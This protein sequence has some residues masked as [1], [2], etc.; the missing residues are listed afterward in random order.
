MYPA[1]FR[2]SYSRGFLTVWLMLC[3]I[4]LPC[5]RFLLKPS[6]LMN[7]KRKTAIAVTM[8]NMTNII[9]HTEALK[10]SEGGE[11]IVKMHGEGRDKKNTDSR[12]I[13][14]I[15]FHLIPR[16]AEGDTVPLLRDTITLMPVSTNG[17][18]K[19]MTSDRSSFM[20]NE[21][22]AIIAF[23][24]YTYRAGKRKHLKKKTE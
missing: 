21:P 8:S 1:C 22:T 19:S 3:I 10:G 20:V 24:L 18:E 4:P 7:S 17:T 12:G 6:G 16:N 5:A 11:R 15:L 14:K 9:T 2:S 23:L 13:S